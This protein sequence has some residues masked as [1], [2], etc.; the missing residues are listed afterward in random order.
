MIY[1]SRPEELRSIRNLATGH[2]EKT[3]VIAGQHG[4]G[5]SSLLAA[6][7]AE[8]PINTVHAT[9]SGTETEWPLSGM[10]VI[11]D[12]VGG[13]GNDALI[14][15]LDRAS[16]QHATSF[17]TATAMLRLVRGFNLDPTLILIDDVDQLDEDSQQ[18]LGHMARRLNG[19]GIRAVITMTSVQPGSPFAGLPTIRLDRLDTATSVELAHAL[20]PGPVDKAVTHT[21]GVAAGGTP[22]AITECLQALTTRQLR[23]DDPM[24][25]PLHP[26]PGTM[27]CV[28]AQLVELSDGAR[29]QLQLLACAHQIPAQ[30]LDRLVDDGQAAL[31]EL[32]Q[33]QLAAR[34]GGRLSIHRPIVRCCLYW[35]Q[36][37]AT[38]LEQHKLLAEAC[39][40]VD[41]RLHR[42]HRS[43]VSHN[44]TSINE[45]MRDGTEF[46]EEGAMTM[47]IEYIER[48]LLLS[49]G[50]DTDGHLERAADALYIR[51]DVSHAIRYAHLARTSVTGPLPPRLAL[52]L[53]ALEF[54]TVQTL[55]VWHLDGADDG[56]SPEDIEDT[57]RLLATAAY[58]RAERWETDLG[59]QRLQRAIAL[60]PDHDGPAAAMITLSR[61]LLDVLDGSVPAELSDPAKVIASLEGLGP[62]KP[63]IL[64]GRI[65]TYAEQYNRARTIFQ[66]ALNNSHAI[67]PLWR[68]TL[69]FFIAENEQRSGN[70]RSALNKVEEAL[71]QSHDHQLHRPTR[72]LLNVWA[73]LM[74]NQ[75]DTA[76]TLTNEWHN[77]NA[78]AA[79]PAISARMYAQ[80]GRSELMDGNYDEAIHHLNRTAEIST[81]IAAPHL[82]GYEADLIEALTCVGRIDEATEALTRLK[83][84]HDNAP[85]RWSELAIAR[86]TAIIA[87]DDVALDL[88][89]DALRQFTTAD[90]DY[91][92]ARTLLAYSQRLEQIGHTRRAHQTLKAAQ[93][94]L[95]EVGSRHRP[96]PASHTEPAPAAP[97]PGL[98]S[99]LT[100]GE[101]AVA[102]RVLDGYR[103]KDIA[104]ELFISLRT[105]EVRLTNI[106]RK[107]SV[108]S[109]SQMISLVSGEG[110]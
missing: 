89:D 92:R 66:T 46:I 22:L 57:C 93:G 31:E 4:F 59:Q 49:D 105:V 34:T 64:V 53:M 1:N 12:A 44:R 76:Q 11:I 21:I 96:Q 55:P 110:Q 16:T 87:T 90:S 25:H 2:R 70:L 29:T 42:W 108:K 14:E 97:G 94:I 58:F 45:L 47:G 86:A 3:L 100:D 38:R 62:Y 74:R 67:V 39:R 91:E 63:L 15:H 41:E 106:Y 109:R 56:I 6:A 19:T 36:P 18:V 27:H 88:F 5:K 72:T 40:G 33:K 101:Q 83:A 77:F 30:V 75:C 28:E 82:L 104:H 80:H 8:R 103:N 20:A 9:P 48:A 95:H 98:L 84:R 60:Q 78:E 13:P 7:A 71:E 81:N 65:L 52:L 69:H 32:L 79:N 61:M 37:P 24:V 51:A 73:N 26:G 85:S 23:G 107:L 54:H 50:T 99:Q 35:S 17:D 68:E 10:S 102:G 43:F